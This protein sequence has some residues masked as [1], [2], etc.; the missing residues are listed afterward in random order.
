MRPISM[1][2]WE[3][4]QIGVPIC[5][6]DNVRSKLKETKQIVHWTHN[7][8]QIYIASVKKT[9]QILLHNKFNLSTF[10]LYQKV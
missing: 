4:I 10:L 3:G 7:K 6:V 1:N 2:S 9:K 8:V 5:E